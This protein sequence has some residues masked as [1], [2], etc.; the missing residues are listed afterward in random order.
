MKF[1]FLH[2]ILVYVR[3]RDFKSINLKK[4]KV[5]KKIRV[6]KRVEQDLFTIPY[7]KREHMKRGIVCPF[8]GRRNLS[9]N[10]R[11]S[12][13]PRNARQAVQKGGTSAP[14]SEKTNA[15]I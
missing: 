1:L 3:Y 2:D 12:L 9:E 14:A 13:T 15:C 11:G 4:K 5:K 7:R 6:T 8:C 10:K